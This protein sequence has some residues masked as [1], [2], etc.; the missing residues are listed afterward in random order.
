MAS[1]TLRNLNKAKKIELLKTQFNAYYSELIYNGKS[2][3]ISIEEDMK[4]L[5][6][7][8]EQPYYTTIVTKEKRVA[9]SVK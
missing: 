4:K 2:F 5:L 6:F 7:G 8:I 3:L 9:N 1:D